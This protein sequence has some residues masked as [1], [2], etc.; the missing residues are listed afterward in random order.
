MPAP[1]P[2][3]PGGDV[4]VTV[5]DEVGEDL[6]VAVPDDG[7]LGDGHDE[8]LAPGAVALLARPVL[9]RGGPPVR[10]V[11]EREQGRGVAVGRR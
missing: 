6:A 4:A 5:A 10:V 7:A 3:A 2:P 8:V 1:A 9:A 11:P